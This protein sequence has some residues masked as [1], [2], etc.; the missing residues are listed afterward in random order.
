[1]H[2]PPGII[3]SAPPTRIGI[4]AFGVERNGSN[5]GDFHSV[6]MDGIRS[7]DPLPIVNH[8]GSPSGARYATLLRTKSVLCLE[9]N[10]IT[11]TKL[12]Q[13]GAELD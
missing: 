7:S 3:R 1:M 5:L 6:Y 8:N 9:V 2:S 4:T 10:A 11:H 13:M 12:V